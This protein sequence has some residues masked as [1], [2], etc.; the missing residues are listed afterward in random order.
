MD[1]LAERFAEEHRRFLEE[2]NPRVL[3]QQDD[4]SSYLSSVGRQ[5]A[6]SWEHQ[7]VKFANSPAVQKL[8]HLERVRALQNHQQAVEEQIL[9]DHIL[10]PVPE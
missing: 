7:M 4:P 10:Q 1:P 8:P 2:N 6:E 3:S 5:A 9:H